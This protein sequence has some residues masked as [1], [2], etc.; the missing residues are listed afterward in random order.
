MDF[1]TAMTGGMAGGSFTDVDVCGFVKVPLFNVIC[2]T[3][4]KP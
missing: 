2:I 1:W 4:S 3:L